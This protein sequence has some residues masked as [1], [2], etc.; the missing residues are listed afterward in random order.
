MSL[1]NLRELFA[2]RRLHWHRDAVYAGVATDL[3][4]QSRF[5]DNPVDQ[6]RPPQWN[7]QTAPPLPS[8]YLRVRARPPD[9]FAPSDNRE[10]V[11][12]RAE[13]GARPLHN[14]RGRYNS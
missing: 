10:K 9:Y 6:P 14:R 3:T 11:L 2:A 13:A 12:P 7:A 5:V 1:G 8:V 4:R